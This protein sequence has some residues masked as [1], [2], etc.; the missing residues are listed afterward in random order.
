MNIL[1]LKCLPINNGRPCIRRIAIIGCVLFFCHQA[2]ADTDPAIND[3]LN[4]LDKTVADWASK[5]NLLKSLT[6]I[7]ALIGIVVSAI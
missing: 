2:L 5:A 3:L 1:R 6:F 4:T 7:A